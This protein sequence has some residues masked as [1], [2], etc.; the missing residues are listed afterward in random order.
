[1]YCVHYYHTYTS[2]LILV[3][4]LT[5]LTHSK[6]FDFLTGFFVP[7]Y[8]YFP[9]P[10]NYDEKL[11]N[12]QLVYEYLDEIKI[13]KKNQPSEI[14][15]GDLRAILRIVYCLFVDFHEKE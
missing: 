5:V 8:E 6:T 3:I 11:H 13:P 9:S 1:M 7:L 14:V 10:K 15:S 2:T 4:N 12:V